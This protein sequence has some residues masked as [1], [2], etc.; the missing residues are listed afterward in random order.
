MKGVGADLKY[1]S[2]SYVSFWLPLLTS[3]VHFS[4]GVSEPGGS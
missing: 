4:V 2:M 3:V 1:V